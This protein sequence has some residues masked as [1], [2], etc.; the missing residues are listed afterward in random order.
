MAVYR[1]EISMSRKAMTSRDRVLTTM[2]RREPDRVP[3]N[4]YGNA[5]I[6]RRL[7]EHFGLTD[8]PYSALLEALGVD[9]RG[10]APEYTGPK[11]HPDKGDIKVDN[12]GVH[13]R[14]V[15]HSTGGYWDYC[16]WPLTHS[17][18]EEIE[19]W[20]MPNPD[21]FDYGRIAAEC[22]KFQDYCVY[23]G[24]AGRP[25]V[26]NG[27]GRLRT[28]EQILVDM[29]TDD[30]AGLKLIEKRTGILLEITRRTLEAA[31]GKIHLLCI[32]E[33]LG[34]QRGPTISPALFRKHIRPHIQ[35]FVDLAKAYNIPT[36]IHCCGSSSWAFDDFIQ[37]G[38]TCA[39]TLQ[40][41]AADMAPAYLKQR[42]GDRLAF[43]GCISTAGPLAYGTP[44]DVEKNV[45][46]TLEIMMPGGGYC[47][48]PTHSIQDNSPTENVLML[49]EAGRK[50]SFYA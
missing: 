31:K 7:T 38:I 34:T 8:Q 16:H 18:V 13:S 49:Y 48:S 27:C 44:A 21:H 24:G 26:I 47:L 2:A 42:Y 17:T 40:P 32:G 46:E 12:W 1:K 23:C 41:E 5:D 39:E 11:L 45:R 50:Y 35:A 37:M 4:Y 6:N 20:P 3:F 15:E 36:M 43:H 28:M 29:I 25:D 30:P 22:D 14:W 10:V 9:F 33:D 19:A